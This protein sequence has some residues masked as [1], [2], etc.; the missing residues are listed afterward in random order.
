LRHDNRTAVFIDKEKLASSGNL[1][2]N[3]WLT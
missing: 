3:C 1:P 2:T